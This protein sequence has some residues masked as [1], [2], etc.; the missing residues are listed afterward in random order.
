M[1]RRR[2][3]STTVLND[4]LDWPDVGQVCQLVRETTRNGQKT[5]DVQYAMSSVGRDQADAKRLLKW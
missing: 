3:T 2:L 5:I 1:E 4:Y